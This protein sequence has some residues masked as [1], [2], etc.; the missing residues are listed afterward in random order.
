MCV[1][2]LSGCLVLVLLI[3]Q[4]V[5]QML[6][7]VGD[8]ISVVLGL[9]ISQGWVVLLQ[10]CFVDEGYDYWVVNVLISGDIFVGGLVCLLVLFVEEKLVLVVIE[11]G[12]NDGLCGMVLV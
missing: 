11:L 3:Q 9:D 12:G 1:L 10:K 2:L 6:L 5:V 4:V 7:V 8:S